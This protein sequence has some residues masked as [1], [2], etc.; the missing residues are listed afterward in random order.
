VTRTGAFAMATTLLAAA[1]AVG[2][3]YKKPSAPVPAAY[4]EEQPPAG[5]VGADMAQWKRAE[6]QDDA[7]RGKWWELFEDPELNALE[8][9]V[10]VSNQNIAQAEAQFRGARAAVRGARADF[11]PTVTVSASVTRSQSSARRSATDTST[12]APAPA[13]AT[14]VYALPVDLSYEVDVW[15]RVRRGVEASVAGAQASAADL[16]TVRL[17]MHAEL[18]LDYFELRGI[19]TQ[20]Q[21]LDSSVAAY[22]KALRMNM[23]RFNQGVVSGVDVAQAQTL[24]ETT[25]AQATDLGVSR[26]QLEHAIATL[27][28]KPPADF[29]FRPAPGLP[30]PPVI[31]VTLPSELLERRPDIAAAERRAAAANAQIGI[32]TAAFFPRLLLAAT[33]GYE[34]SKLADWFSLPSRFWSIGPSL[35]ATIFDGGKRRSEVEQARASYDAAVA[36]Y[37]LDVLTSFQQVEDNLATLR[38]LAEEAAQ[39]AAAVAAAERSLTI[40]RNRY[41]AGTTTYLEVVTAQTIALSNQRAAV[42]IQTRRMTAAVNLIKALGGGWRAYDLPYGYAV[43]AGQT[44][45]PPEAP[46]KATETRK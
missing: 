27:I 42:D 41:L 40:A 44:V 29:T 46:A 43:T 14:T 30:G 16:E 17:T 8:E 34:S 18:A 7:G 39:Q 25:R 19:D 36:V 33:G 3:N 35:V 45:P 13:A 1:C 6:P 5:A 21:L 12:S 9:Q 20:K 26:A 32:A 38:I 37:R 2:P 23:N 24:L 15:G 11:F 10:N 28:G 22:E 4:K 31:P